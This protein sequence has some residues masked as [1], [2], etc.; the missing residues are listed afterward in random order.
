MLTERQ[1]LVKLDIDKGM[2]RPTV[3]ELQRLLG[4]AGYVID[5][6]ME[7][8]SKSGAGY[9]IVLSVDPRPRTAAEV[10][11]LQAI[12]GSDPNREACNLLRSRR[13]SKLPRF[14]RDRWNVLYY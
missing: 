12:L 2:H 14:W 8:R 4:R 7:K 6:L 3:Y 9:H 10:V 1:A 11:A 5:W 13:W